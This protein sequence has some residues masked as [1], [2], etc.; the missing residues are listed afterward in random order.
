MHYKISITSRCFFIY[1][2]NISS[3]HYKLILWSLKKCRLNCMHSFWELCVRLTAL[4]SLSF[5]QVDIRMKISMETC[6]AEDTEASSSYM[7][8]EYMCDEFRNNSHLM[9]LSKV[10]L[11][12]SEGNWL[13]KWR[14]QQCMML[15]WKW[16]LWMSAKTYKQRQ[17]YKLD[18]PSDM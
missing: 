11:K 2:E 15:G 7:R 18:K 13:P 5:T 3:D 6:L 1:T 9:L 4:K 10:F 8:S 16:N 12:H 14:R 17:S